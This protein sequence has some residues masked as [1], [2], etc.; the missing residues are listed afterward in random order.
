MLF[1]DLDTAELDLWQNIFLEKV[2]S[3]IKSRNT[4]YISLG[5]NV[6]DTFSEELALNLHILLF[7][8]L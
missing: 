1:W 4:S 3:L 8:G 7:Y 5:D 6:L 2:A